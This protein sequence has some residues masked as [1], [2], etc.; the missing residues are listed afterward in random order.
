MKRKKLGE[1]LRERGKI[2]LDD[3]QNVVADQQGKM[4]YLGEI[5]L[6]RGLVSKLDIAAALEEVSHFPYL[7]CSTVIADAQALAMVTRAVAERCLALPIRFEG[8]SLVVAMAEP[9]NLAIVAELRFTT[10][11]NISPHLAFRSELKDAIQRYYASKERPAASDKGS[12]SLATKEVV[13]MGME[14]IKFE[15]IEFFSTSTRQS[16]Q[17]AIQ[18]M[19]ADLRQRK[20]PA[21]QLVSEMIQMALAKHASDIHIE[22][23]A[24]QTSVRI[25]VDGVLRDLQSIPRSLQKSLV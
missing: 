7:D 3:L 15:E 20:T 25:R 1:V 16:N 11:A 19:Q 12:R 8:K 17:E 4:L 13:T 21:V 6:E 5:L 2:S 22:P 24:Y 18:E 10:G 9:Q 23:R 14:D